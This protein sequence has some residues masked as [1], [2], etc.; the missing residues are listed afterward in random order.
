MR[1]CETQAI[2]FG[3]LRK[4]RDFLSYNHHN[5]REAQAALLFY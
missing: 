2:R 3:R 5:A 4:Q 1:I